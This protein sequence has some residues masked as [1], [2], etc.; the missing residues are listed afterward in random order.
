MQ[1]SCAVELLGGGIVYT[2]D[3]TDLR[4]ESWSTTVD[5]GVAKGSKDG[6]VYVSPNWPESWLEDAKQGCS[7]GFLS[8]V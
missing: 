3:T 5:S 6:T 1:N 2:L 4:P 7:L 8:V